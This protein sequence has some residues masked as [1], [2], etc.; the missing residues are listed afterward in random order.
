M[1]VAKRDRLFDAHVN[2]ATVRPFMVRMVSEDH[3][4]FSIV[5]LAL[6]EVSA[7]ELIEKITGQV[8]LEVY[9]L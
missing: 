7:R 1:F 9:P 2:R 6:D 5:V 3:G 8:T 4:A